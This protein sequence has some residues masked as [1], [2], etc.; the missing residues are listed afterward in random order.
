MSNQPELKRGKIRQNDI[1]WRLKNFSKVMQNGC[2][3]WKNYCNKDGYGR[4]RYNGKKHLAHRVSYEIFKKPFNKSLLVCH[5]CDNPSC[6]NPEHLFLGTHQDNVS[7]CKNKG[8]HKGHLNSPFVKGH[9][10]AN[11]R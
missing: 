9:Q 3:E 2:W 4:V 11:R 1:V 7:D 8:R 6:I 10:L 5:T